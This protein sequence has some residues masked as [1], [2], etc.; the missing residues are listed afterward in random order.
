MNRCPSSSFNGSELKIKIISFLFQSP[1]ETE[2]NPLIRLLEEKVNIEKK[3][4]KTK[5]DKDERSQ[6]NC[7]VNFF[8]CIAHHIIPIYSMW[9]P[10]HNSIPTHQQK[11]L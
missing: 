3:S 1:T 5:M 10:C 8:L 2:F 7:G 11:I 9:L 6:S 4:E